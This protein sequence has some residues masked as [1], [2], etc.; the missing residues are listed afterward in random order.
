MTRE[1][2]KP[3]KNLVTGP[4]LLAMVASLAV[5]IAAGFTGQAIFSPGLLNSQ[6]SQTSLGGVLSHS[7]L[8]RRCSACHAPPWQS[9]KMAQRCLS[10][11]S[12]I[13]MQMKNGLPVSESEISCRNG[14]HTEHRGPDSDLTLKAGWNFQ[15]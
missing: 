15:N 5:V 10:C 2:Y 13:K 6:A 11:H 9:D 4:R 14:C 7:E 3:R 12:D 1:F 8:S